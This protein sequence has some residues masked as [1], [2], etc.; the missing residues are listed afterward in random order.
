MKNNNG[1]FK[2]LFIGVSALAVASFS[3]LIIPPKISQ[4]FNDLSTWYTYLIS[5]KSVKPFKIIGIPI[6]E[7]SLNNIHQRWPWKRSVYAEILKIL[8]REKVSTVGID[9]VFVGESETKEEDLVLR[10]ALRNSS[11]KPV[12]AYFFDLKSGTPVLPP[13]EVKDA[14]Y[15]IGMVDTPVDPDGITRRLRGYVGLK[16]DFYYSFSLAL[17][18]AFLNQKPQD[19]A[20]SIPLSED[21]TF[22]I[23][24]LLKP[25]DILRV[26]FY[27]VLMNLPEL[28]K[29][30]GNDFLK[31][32]LVLVYPETKISRD[33][34]NTPLGMLPGGLLHLNGVADILSKRFL[35]KRETFAIP[36]LVFSFICIL[37]ILRN[38]GIIAGF[39]ISVGVL[40]I[41]FWCSVILNLNGIRLDYYPFVIFC[42]SFFILGSIYRYLSFLTQIIKIKDKATLDPLRNIFTLRYFY[43]RL[44]LETKKIYFKRDLFLVFI[45]LGSFKDSSPEMGMEYQKD[46][47]KRISAVLFQKGKFWSVYS[48]DEVVG[49][50]ISSTKKI[51]KE[52]NLLKNNLDSLFRRRGIKAKAKFSFVRLKKSY[53]LREL[54]FVLSAELRRKDSKD[55]VFLRE[56]DLAGMLE[57]TAV[58]LVDSGKFLESLDQD[59][60]ERNRQLLTL[61]ENLNREQARTKEAF[62]QIISSLVNALE[63]RDSYTEGHSDRVSQYSLLIAESLGWAADEKEKLRKAAL[64][65]DLGKI[66]IPDRIL[67]KRAQLNEEEYDLIKKHE[68][69]GVKIL[70]PLKDLS[71][72]L[73]WILYH[74]EKWDGTGYPH[75]LSANAIPEAS[76]I[77]ALAD[78]YDALTTSR[79]YKSAFSK[80]D[81]LKEII[82]K[83]GI[84]FNP[85][86]VDIFVDILTR[87]A[88]PHEA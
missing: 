43:Y 70:E 31:G 13:Q 74:H 28:K 69:I 46:I 4:S 73:P 39:L 12:L 77:I 32:A 76:Q 2:L 63:A 85:K 48:Q 44:S 11:S 59:I 60:E 45:Y 67:H 33:M 15:S 21:K 29:K 68:I 5:N 24:Y 9:L 54:L 41:D 38:H 34:H 3:S 49:F 72:I 81:S 23:N 30:Y 79:D 83:K 18:A 50:L 27:D 14:A 84:H 52:L 53:P 25:K 56:E 51:S 75:G 36:V 17:S 71:D 26:S 35:I 42:S 62:F 8:D 1:Y 7:Y 65:H 58:K 82:G 57:S 78:V 86:L 37:Y 20:L 6:D 87:K 88:A 16:N 19:V 66:G 55:S 64:L 61:I 22:F 10:D 47:W 80:E 40:I